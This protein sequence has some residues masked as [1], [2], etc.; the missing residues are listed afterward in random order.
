M[1]KIDRYTDRIDEVLGTLPGDYDGIIVTP[2]T[3][4]EWY[5]LWNVFL[6]HPDGW[7]EEPAHDESAKVYEHAVNFTGHAFPNDSTDTGWCTTWWYEDMG[8]K[9]HHAWY[10]FSE[11][12]SPDLITEQP[13]SAEVFEDMF[14]EVSV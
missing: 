13:I 9:D 5:I 12:F 3:E 1:S 6:Q 11:L 2:E 10:K 7:W 8:Y 14:Q 4:E